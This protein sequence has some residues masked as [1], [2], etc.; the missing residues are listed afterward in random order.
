MLMNESAFKTLVGVQGTVMG[1]D[2]P[3]HY[4]QCRAMFR[5]G[6]RKYFP[7]QDPRPSPE[8]FI[9]FI[10]ALGVDFYLHQ[11][12]PDEKE[13][14]KFIDS[15]Q[16]FHISFLIGNE[17]G[18][19]NGPYTDGTNRYDV[20]ACSVEKAKQ[21][22]KLLGL[23]YDETEHLQLHPFM[24]SKEPIDVSCRKECDHQW[25]AT[26]G[27]QLQQLEDD[28][29]AAVQARVKAYGDHVDVYS[30][31]V[32]PV[33]YHV[34]A[35]GGMNPCPKVLKEEFQ[36]LQL[37]SALGAAKQYKR[38]M[39]IC[40]DLWGPDVGKWFTRLWGFPGHSPQEYKSALEMAYLMGPDLMYTEN[41]DPLAVY[42]GQNFQKTEFGEV[43]EEFIK[44]FIPCHPRFYNH[45]MI[46]P[47]IVVIRSD[48]GVISD[49]GNFY[50]RGLY[51]SLTLMSDHRT[52][53]VFDVFYLVSHGTIPHN[54][55]T[56]FLPQ[57][58]FP[59]GEYERNADTIKQ[60]PLVDGVTRED[61]KYI[62]K[63]FYPMNN[64]AVFDERVDSQTLGKPKLILLAGSRMTDQCLKLVSEKVNDGSVCIAA[65]W[66]VPD[67]I[68]SGKDGAGKW[69]IVEDF[70]NDAVWD[71]AAPFLGRKDCWLQKFGE[72]EV[73]FYN[74][75]G[76]GITLTH[77]VRKIG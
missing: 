44:K 62:H 35:R 28:T 53:S 23:V 66:L 15:I 21:T 34:L 63:L 49:D 20:P 67:F 54:G 48:D 47:D 16:Q 3:W 36:S 61:Q 2:D 12:A 10:Q 5:T 73:R 50:G 29:A 27:K 74:P 45:S 1:W 75:K 33:L 41:I 6:E 37:A 58:Q 30:E 32:F 22:G 40:V 52:Q 76:D 4:E 71:A 57:F 7:S 11:V 31:Q 60:L 17:Y 8:Q 42:N 64:V 9:R 46:Q 56:F 70:R 24:Y 65:S 13:I 26:R 25:T 55:V 38:K 72:Y 39:G 69:L 77:E 18:A 59:I 68:K 19:I 43:F 14:D 51:G